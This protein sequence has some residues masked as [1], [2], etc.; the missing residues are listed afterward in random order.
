MST[1]LAEPVELGTW[2]GRA[3]TFGLLASYGAAGQAQHLL[4][5]RESGAYKLLHLSWDEFCREHAGLSRPRVDELIRCLEQFGETYFRLTELVPVSP[6]AY[7]L[8]EPRIQ[9]QQLEIDGELVEISPENALRIRQAILRLRAELKAT[10]DLAERASMPAIADLHR[11]LDECFH[12]MHALATG[13]LSEPETA[14]LRGLFN[15]ATCSLQRL[16]KQLA[17]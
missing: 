12:Q 3:Q 15:F 1:E 13:E 9:G 16:A 17:A 14:G 7:R 8:L 10:R 2:I 11:R 5:I 4:R 6:A